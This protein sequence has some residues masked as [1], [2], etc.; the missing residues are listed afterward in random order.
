MSERRGSSDPFP[1]TPTIVVRELQEGASVQLDPE[2][3]REMDAYEK[4]RFVK[5]RDSGRTEGEIRI[6]KSKLTRKELAEQLDAAR[7][8]FRKRRKAMDEDWKTVESSIKRL[9]QQSCDFIF[10]T[11]PEFHKILDPRPEISALWLQ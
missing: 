4:R 3:E 2:L 11:D 9:S 10:P 8:I 5:R 6:I 7:N 1:E